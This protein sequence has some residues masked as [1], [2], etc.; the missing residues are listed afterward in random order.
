MRV[1]IEFELD[2]I[3]FIDTLLT[4]MGRNFSVVH[5]RASRRLSLSERKRV[6]FLW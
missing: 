6:V 4:M 2:R 5:V 3:F 1:V